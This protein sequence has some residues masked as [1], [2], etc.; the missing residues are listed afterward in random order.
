[1]RATSMVAIG[2][3]VLARREHV[4]AIEPGGK[5]LFAMTLRYPNEIRKE[6]DYF[7][8]VPDVKLDKELLELAAHI[9]KTK[10][11]HF[12]PA[13]FEDRYESA[14]VDLLRKKQAGQTIEPAKPL[15]SP[16]VINLMEALRASIAADTKKPPAPSVRGKRP[17]AAG[18]KK[19][20]R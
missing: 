10:A 18:K 14:L 19:A 12:D 11:G 4:L 20:A 13:Q 7:E 16:K 1:M 17:A 3:V 8:D 9:V 5:G 2:R 6:A 15:P